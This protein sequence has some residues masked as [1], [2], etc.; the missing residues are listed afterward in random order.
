MSPSSFNIRFNLAL[1]KIVVSRQT[2]DVK[3]QLILFY[4]IYTNY[5]YKLLSKVKKPE[6]S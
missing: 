3:A 4:I 6:I 5:N 1:A 2:Q